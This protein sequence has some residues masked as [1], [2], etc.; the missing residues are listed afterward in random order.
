MYQVRTPSF[1]TYSSLFL[2]LSFFVPFFFKPGFN[3]GNNSY[4]IELTRFIQF[5]YIGGVASHVN[6]TAIF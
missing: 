4:K 3:N 1:T 6:G 2:S 5:I